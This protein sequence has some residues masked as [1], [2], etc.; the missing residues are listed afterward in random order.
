MRHELIAKRYIKPLMES[1]DQV[2]L[3]NLSTLLSTVAKAYENEKFNLIMNSNDVSSSAKCQLILDMVAS[4]NSTT[5]N[6]LIKLLAENGRLSL[7]PVIADQL[8]R[9]IGRVKRTFKGRIYSNN[10]VDQA[11]VDTI[12][13]DLGTKMGATISLSYVASDFDGIR[14]EVDDLNVEINFSKSRLNAQLVEH[15][16]KAI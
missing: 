16:L 9:E 2:S 10:V 11:S 7:I 6:N 14:V 13:R 8:T 12:A 3:D 5:V 1:C 15:I 4:A